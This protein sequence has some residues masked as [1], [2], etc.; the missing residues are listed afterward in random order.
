MGLVTFRYAPFP[1][2]TITN[3][4][5]SLAVDL[6]IRAAQRFGPQE[7]RSGIVGVRS[8]RETVYNDVG[9]LEVEFEKVEE[10]QVS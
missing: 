10:T 5:L 8:R 6:V 4:N 2:E 7:I 1:P 3:I 9:Q